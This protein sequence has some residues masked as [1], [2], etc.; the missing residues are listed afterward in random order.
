M[1]SPLYLEAIVAILLEESNILKVRVH[2]FFKQPIIIS[3]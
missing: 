1:H 3:F 2:V